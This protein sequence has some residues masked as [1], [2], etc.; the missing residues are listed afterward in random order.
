MKLKITIDAE[1]LPENDRKI[2][3]IHRPRNAMF[4]RRFRSGDIEQWK[5]AADKLGMSDTEFLERTMSAAAC[6]VLGK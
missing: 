2:D 5:K 1:P 4:A 6:A 3:L